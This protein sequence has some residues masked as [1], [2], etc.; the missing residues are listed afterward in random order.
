MR[1]T[2]SAPA[3]RLPRAS[4]SRN[5]AVPASAPEKSPPERSANRNWAARQVCPGEGRAA[6]RSSN[7]ASRPAI[8]QR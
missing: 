1:R 4:E 8:V 3:Q 2:K 6:Q 7:A 5:S